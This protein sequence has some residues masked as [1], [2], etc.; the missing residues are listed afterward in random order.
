MNAHYGV[1]KTRRQCTAFPYP[2]LSSHTNIAQERRQLEQELHV[3]IFPGTEI[4][5]D[6]RSHHFVKSS[7]RDVMVPQPS[8]DPHGPLNW[9]TWWKTAC[10]LATAMVTF[11]QGFGPL[12]LASMFPALMEAF[13]WDLADAIQFTGVCILVLGFSNFIWSVVHLVFTIMYKAHY[14]LRVPISTSFGRRPVFLLSQLINFGTSIWRAR[15]K[16]YGSFMGACIVNGIGAG[17]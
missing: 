9:N 2:S 6:I 5:A 4:M 1:R 3:E 8:G 10:I 12:A 13:Q 16:S 15:A 17:P 14:V 11:T 7:H